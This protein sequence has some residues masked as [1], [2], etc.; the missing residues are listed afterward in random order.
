MQTVPRTVT[1]RIPLD[2]YGN[3]ITTPATIIEP[4][5]EVTSEKPETTD[6]PVATEGE[7]ADEAPSLSPAQAAEAAEKVEEQ[8][9]PLTEADGTSA[10][11]TEET[12]EETAADK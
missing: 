11:G 3:P 8:D 6:I 5:T 9:P 12:T 10:E 2:A 1:M 4:A 7:A